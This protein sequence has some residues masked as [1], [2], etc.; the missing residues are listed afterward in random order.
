MEISMPL[1][2]SVSHGQSLT[3]C[4]A[5]VLTIHPKS[6]TCTYLYLTKLHFNIY[7]YLY[8]YI[9]I[10]IYISHL[11]FVVYISREDNINNYKLFI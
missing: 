11:I 10:Y 5:S 9:Y 2:G 4:T 3:I 8:I 6:M 7:I 1:Q